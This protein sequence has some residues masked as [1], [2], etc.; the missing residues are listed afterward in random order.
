MAKVTRTVVFMKALVLCADSE[1]GELVENYY[2]FPKAMTDNKIKKE[3]EKDG[4]LVFVKVKEKELVSE[5]F[6]ISVEDFMKYATKVE[7]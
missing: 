7:E 4:T 6:A 5:K 1:K 2:N 3:V